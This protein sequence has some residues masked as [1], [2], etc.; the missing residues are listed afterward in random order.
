MDTNGLNITGAVCAVIFY[1]TSI[2][3]FVSRLCRAGGVKRLILTH[4][5]THY[6]DY[7]RH[8]AEAR[9]IFKNAVMAEERRI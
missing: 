2:L 5:L 9:D 8:L 1:V 4:R 7:S 6:A 3:V